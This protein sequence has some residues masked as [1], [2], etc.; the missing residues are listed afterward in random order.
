MIQDR[1]SLVAFSKQ[2]ALSSA[3]ASGDYQIGVNSGA[4]A[5]IEINEEDF[6]T[7]WSSRLLEGHDRGTT[8]PGSAF[9][10]LAMPK[11]IGLLLKAVLGSEQFTPGSP[12]THVFTP[13]VELPYVTFFAVR[14]TEKYKIG[15][16]RIGE[17]ELSWEN[18]K[19]L[20]VKITAMGCTYEFVLDYGVVESERPKDGVLKGAGGTFTIDGNAA[21][22]KGGSIKISNNVEPQHGSA[23]PLPVDVFPATQTVEVSLTILPDNMQ[24]FRKAVTGTTNGTT[25]SATPVYGTVDCSWR[26]D[27]DRVLTFDANDVRFMV[28]FGDV[29]AE[30]GPV[31]L[32]LEG[33]VANRSAT[34][35]SFTLTNTVAQAY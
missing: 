30:G 21:V 19:A 5:N 17:L 16:C 33:A 2:T 22:I 18:T 29:K 14:G 11:T 9:E 26:V 34:P 7:T 35:V 25:V 28:D 20:V 32:S 1:V 4:I 15:D 12:N 13:G 6:P 23:S 24:L 3:A 10:T 31:E 27:A 8:V